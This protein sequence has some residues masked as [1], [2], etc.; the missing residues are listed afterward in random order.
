M[1]TPNHRPR[2]TDEEM[3]A[4][5]DGDPALDRAAFERRLEAAPEARRDLAAYRKLYEALATE[6]AFALADFPERVIRRVVDEARAEVR[7]ASAARVRTP[8]LEYALLALVVVTAGVGGFLLRDRLA[9]SLPG[10]AWLSDH[11]AWIGLGAAV[12]LVVELADQLV[13]RLLRFRR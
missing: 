3:Q 5:L 9:A 13:L 10:F 1:T 12:L 11:L 2:P 8:W 4:Y 6:P 7:A